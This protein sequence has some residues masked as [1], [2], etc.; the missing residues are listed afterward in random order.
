MSGVK[1][2]VVST[3]SERGGDS[4]VCLAMDGVTQKLERDCGGEEQLATR[5]VEAQTR[6]GDRD[7]R[8]QAFVVGLSLKRKV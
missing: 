2:T 1:A 7:Y 8:A 4:N 6:G 3:E 5:L